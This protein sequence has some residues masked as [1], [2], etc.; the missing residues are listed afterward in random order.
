[1]RQIL[2]KN[3]IDY[4]LF[5]LSFFIDLT[6]LNPLFQFS[7]NFAGI[8]KDQKIVFPLSFVE[9]DEEKILFIDSIPVLFPVSNIFKPYEIINGNLYFSHDF[10]KSAFYLLSGYQEWNSEK[11]DSL[12][13]FPYA[14]SIHDKLGII[15]KPVVN[16][17][18]EW[19]INGLKE[20]CTLYQIPYKLKR[21]FEK[22]VFILSHDIDRIKKYDFYET[23]HKVM[24]LLGLKPTR[25]SYFKILKLIPG[26]FFH[27]LFGSKKTDPFWNFKSIRELER[28]LGINST[29]YFLEKHAGHDN[30]RYSFNDTAIREL[31]Q[32]LADEKCEIGLHGTVQSATS[33]Q[34]MNSTLNNLK[35]NTSYSVC[36]NRQHKLIFSNPKTFQ[37]Q[38][39]AGLK[40][41]HTLTYAEHEGFRNSFCFP[42]HPYD[43]END[44]MM[45]IWE[46]PLI[47]MDGTLFY[48][49]R[50]TY[51]EI[52]KQLSQLLDEIGKFGG[53][54]SLLWHNSHF[55]EDEFPGIADFYETLL[56]NIISKGLTLK[57]AIDALE[58]FK[59]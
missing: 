44:Q 10:L 34:S 51:T 42:F 53:I 38:Q 24:E 55:D 59:P 21:P 47:A 52:E 48:Y 17:Y 37:I 49:R 30:S 54:F 14:D 46:I 6:D 3:Q 15:E 35:K 50:L 29:W 56:Q 36:G 16:Y 43:F 18:F 58:N 28:K 11:S 12:G 41:D 31:M 8:S 5:H 23:A 7:E 27:F 32:F 33:L 2:N 26:Y 1:M 39:K 4:V 13:R 19:I 57:T 20:F 25:F 22:P 45:E 40:Y 9:L